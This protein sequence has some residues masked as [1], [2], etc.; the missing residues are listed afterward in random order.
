[1]VLAVCVDNNGGMAFGN[2]R[3]SRDIAV[4]RDLVDAC[5]GNKLYIEEY[6]EKIFEEVLGLGAEI[7]VVTSLSEIFCGEDDCVFIELLSPS[8]FADKISKIIMYK[9]NRD[10]PYDTEFDMDMTG[11]ELMSMTEFSGKSHE[12]ITREVYVRAK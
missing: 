8:L 7:N 6:S 2:R 4:C 9:W 3:Q 1:M 11:W 12:K 10:Y 5:K